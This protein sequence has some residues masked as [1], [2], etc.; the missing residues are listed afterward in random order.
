MKATVPCAGSTSLPTTEINEE[1]FVLIWLDETIQKN[2]DTVG[3]EQRL[4]AIVNSLHTCHQIS[5]AVDIIARVK[6]QQVYL[7]VSGGL[8]KQVVRSNDIIDSPKLNS[9]YIFC[10]DR[11]KYEAL[12]Q[13]YEKVRG[14]FVDV[15]PLCARLKADT[16]RA[17]ENLLPISTTAGDSAAQKNR[18]KF[19]RAQLQRELLFTMECNNNA[20]WELADFCADRYRSTPAELK[21]IQELRDHYHAGMALSW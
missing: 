19:L 9:I 3:T 18:E 6:D 20:Q 4:R 21:Y 1:S 8:G 7:I 2:E 16:E 15:D 14:V 13:S 10:H 17:L 5:E 11:S 12:A